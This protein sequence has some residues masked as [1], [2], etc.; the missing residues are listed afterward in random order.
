MLATSAVRTECKSERITEIGLHLTN[1][2]QKDCMGVFLTQNY[3]NKPV[4]DWF[5]R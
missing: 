1:V 2:S 4:G 3:N 5:T